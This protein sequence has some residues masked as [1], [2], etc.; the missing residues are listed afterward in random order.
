METTCYFYLHDDV[1]DRD[2][3]EFD[4]ETNE[5]HD[6]KSNGCGHGDLLEF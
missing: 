1:V 2:V 3:N 6:G 4:E 5:T